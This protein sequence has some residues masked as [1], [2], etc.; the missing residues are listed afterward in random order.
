MSLQNSISEGASCAPVQT[1]TKI[2]FQSHP[3]EHIVSFY[4]VL[5]R[6][7]KLPELRSC[8]GSHFYVFQIFSS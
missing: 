8:P 2:S 4:N 3:S 6:Q 7:E 1:Y 5:L